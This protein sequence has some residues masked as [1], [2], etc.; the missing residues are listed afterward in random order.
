MLSIRV[1][2]TKDYV[3]LLEQLYI[4]LQV[5][6]GHAESLFEVENLDA[7]VQHHHPCPIIVC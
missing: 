6:E 7:Q 4:S 2:S 1:D 3:H 5:R